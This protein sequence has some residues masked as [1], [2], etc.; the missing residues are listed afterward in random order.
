MPTNHVIKNLLKADRDAGHDGRTLF[1]A[2]ILQFHQVF[3]AKLATLGIKLDP[4]KD[5]EMTL[6]HLGLIDL[7]SMATT[8]YSALELVEVSSCFNKG[9]GKSETTWLD[10]LTPKVVI[11][12]RSL[13][14]EALLLPWTESEEH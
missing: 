14:G 13:K 6:E 11:A 9:S 8:S 12:L 2:D 3:R 5:V 10:E 4:E 7:I 1:Q